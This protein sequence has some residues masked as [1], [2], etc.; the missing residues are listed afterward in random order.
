LLDLLFFPPDLL[1]VLGQQKR[2]NRYFGPR[3]RII[4][5]VK[6]TLTMRATP[7]V[8]TEKGD[9]ETAARTQVSVQAVAVDSGESNEDG[10]A[11]ILSSQNPPEN[12]EGEIA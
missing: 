4:S 5:H 2:R 12:T 8:V 10:V 11:Q 9:M 1:L 6:N 7:E 3:S